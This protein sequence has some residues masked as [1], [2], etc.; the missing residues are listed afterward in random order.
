MAV[1]VVLRPGPRLPSRVVP[2]AD[3]ITHADRAVLDAVAALRTQPLTWLMLF[4]SLW[5]VKSVLIG[6][7]GV[8]A[9]LLRRPRRLPPTLVPVAAAV[10]LAEP[11][12][13]LL[14]GMSDRAR[15]PIADPGLAALTS[16]PASASMPSGHALTAFAAAGVVAALHPRLRVA[17]LAAASLVALSRV[18]LGVHFPSDVVVGAAAGLLL[19]ALALAAS[20]W[21]PRRTAAGWRLARPRPE[22]PG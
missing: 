2:V 20:A 6:A 17:A 8:A 4:L 9:D 7:A 11:L 21:R 19:A 16:V 1:C 14:K 15:P 22:P 18:Y 3:A 5:W 12:A 10:L 13:I